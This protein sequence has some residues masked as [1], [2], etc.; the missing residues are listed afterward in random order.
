MPRIDVVLFR[1]E[2]GS[3]PVIDWLNG[4]PPKAQDK[5]LAAL[6]RLAALA[7]ELRRPIADY[8]RDDIYE[9]CVGLRGVNYRILYFFHGQT[10]AIVSHGLVKEKVVPSKEIEKAIR[11]KKVF[12]ADPVAHGLRFEEHP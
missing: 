2:D 5:C 10:A 3:V 7:H 6:R 8:L 11:R 9:L 12:E 1:E 4:L